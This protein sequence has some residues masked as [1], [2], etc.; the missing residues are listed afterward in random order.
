[1]VKSDSIVINLIKQCVV[2][3]TVLVHCHSLRPV[4]VQFLL[5]AQDHNMT[6]GDFAFFTFQTATGKGGVQRPWN[7]VHHPE[8]IPRLRQAFYVV[9][10][11]SAYLS[12]AH[13]LAVVCIGLHGYGLGQRLGQLMG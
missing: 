11:V 9:K 1:M 4:A 3:R 10:W 5:R 7:D 13:P 6:N 12:H 8:D 2:I